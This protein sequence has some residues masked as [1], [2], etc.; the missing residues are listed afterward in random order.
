MFPNAFLDILPQFAKELGT[1]HITEKNLGDLVIITGDNAS[2]KSFLRRVIGHSAKS[3]GVEFRNTSMEGRSG[4]NFFYGG[5]DWQCTSIV[6][7]FSVTSALES[8][9]QDE[10]KSIVI[11]DEPEIGLSVEAQVSMGKFIKNNITNNTNPNRLSVFIMT[12]SHYI[13]RELL[14]IPNTTFISLHDK[15]PDVESWLNREIVPIDFDELSD[16][17]INRFR[18]LSEML[19]DMKYGK[20][21]ATKKSKSTKKKGGTSV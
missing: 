14:D 19:D 1:T 11:I 6:T 3:Y 20:N 4:G 13:V 8:S 17:Y 2:G 15:Y 7:I 5:E 12:H 21:K 16:I 18:N 9:I 10:N